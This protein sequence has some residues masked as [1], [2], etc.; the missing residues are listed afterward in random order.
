MALRLTNAGDYAIRSMIFIASLP[1]DAVVLRSEICETQKIPSSFMAKI[2]RSLV[3]AQLLRSTRGVNGG[4]S[5]A[6]PA[7]KVTLLDIL[8]SIEGPLALTDCVPSPEECEHSMNCPANAVWGR[9]QNSIK[10]IL[11][12]STLED[13]VNTPRRNARVVVIEDK[14]DPSDS[15]E[16]STGA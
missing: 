1:E 14:E 10:E 4:F 2:L 3:R 5:L 9:V 8:E 13:L 7:S 12:S 15:E 16:S 6:R 11:R